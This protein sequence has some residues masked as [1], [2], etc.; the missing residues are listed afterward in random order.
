VV[1]PF[2]MMTSEQTGETEY[3]GTVMVSFGLGCS[4]GN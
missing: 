2:Y 4:A 1:L 3:T